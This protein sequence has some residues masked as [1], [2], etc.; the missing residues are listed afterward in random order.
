MDPPVNQAQR[1]CI[2][3]HCIYKYT[4]REG[5]WTPSQS[6]T[7]ALHTATLHIYRDRKGRWTMPVN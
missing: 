7:E 5:R 1:P 3:L 6:S 2:P 4:E